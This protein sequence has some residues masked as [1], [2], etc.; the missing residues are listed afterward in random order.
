M[1]RIKEFLTRRNII[2]LIILAVL[3]VGLLVGLR[4][5]Q[6]QQQLKS[7]AAGEWQC[8]TLNPPL[9]CMLFSTSPNRD[10]GSITVGQDVYVFVKGNAG[11][12]NVRLQGN[13]NSI[14]VS[15]TYDGAVHVGAD[16]VTKCG[17]SSYQNCWIFKIPGSNITSSTQNYSETFVSTEAS[18]GTVASSF[19]AAAARGA[20]GNVAP[21]T[22][23]GRVTSTGSGNPGIGG[24]TIQIYDDTFNQQTRS[25]NTDANG[26]Y[27]LAG[28]V[29]NGDSYR[30]TPPL[31][32]PQGFT[33]IASPPDYNQQTAGGSPDCKTSC[34]FTFAPASPHLDYNAEWVLPISVQGDGKSGTIDNFPAPGLIDGKT[35]QLTI[36]MK[37]TTGGNAQPWTTSYKFQAQSPTDQDSD[38]GLSAQSISPRYTVNPGDPPYAFGITIRPKQGPHRFVWRMINDKNEAFGA[39]VDIQLTVVASPAGGPGPSPSP[40]PGTFKVKLTANPTVVESDKDLT[41]ITWVITGVP[42]G[43]QIDSCIASGD[44]NWTG[45]Q[46]TSS[47]SKSVKLT[48]TSGTDALNKQLELVCIT[49]NEKTATGRATVTVN[50]TSPSPS[51][52]PSPGGG[53][54]FSINKPSD[55]IM[56]KGQAQAGKEFVVSKTAGSAE[57]VTFAISGNTGGAVAIFSPSVACKPDPSTCRRT[58]TFT[59][60]N[61]DPGDYSVTIQG[62][63]TGG[64]SRESYP[65]NLKI[66]PSPPIVTCF[67]V[68]TSPNTRSLFNNCDP[69]KISSMNKPLESV[70]A[71]FLDSFSQTFDFTLP[72]GNGS[73][74]LYA[75]FLQIPEGG[76]LVGSCAANP[77]KC[78]ETTAGITLVLPKLSPCPPKG[79]VNSD[80]QV[81]NADA[82]TVLKSVVGNITLTPAQKIIADVTADGS[83]GS[84]DANTILQYA[85]G[86]ILTFPACS[87]PPPPVTNCVCQTDNT[88]SS[89]CQFT[90]LTDI[91]YTDPISCFTPV[92][93]HN[94]APSSANKNA[95]CNRLRRTEGDANADGKIDVDDY[96]YFLTAISLGKVP[97]SVDPDF[98]GDGQIDLDDLTIW[99]RSTNP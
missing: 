61:A 62:T 18:A 52:S 47:S 54:D 32:A 89:P 85:E 88:C 80:G 42:R 25:V 96:L 51:P 82:D 65:F 45:S 35:Y 16:A 38:L 69:T 21:V 2:A 5:V 93:I 94:I 3:A 19:Q 63:S 14:S 1:E 87:P 28:F 97:V 72:S 10:G 48:N 20:T 55:F 74:P 43:E 31:T 49:N 58:V 33:G 91:G 57:D 4:L 99:E 53:F 92:R 29:R 76:S 41:T 22:I 46:T 7:Q 70:I 83:I 68:S 26:N 81:S 6:Q 56:T 39:L 98:D 23:G 44:P 75:R 66:N 77:T 8:D 95:Y 12:T 30:V 73:K 79:D 50:K 71:G 34:N 59:T 17:D 90:K 78:R 15:G 13:P 64:L 24:I 60:A 84:D 37:N 67:V 27:S 11:G 36:L 40:S 86:T 9:F